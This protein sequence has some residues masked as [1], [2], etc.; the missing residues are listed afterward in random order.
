MLKKTLF[1]LSLV[2]ALVFAGAALAGKTAGTSSITGP[3]VVAASPA[4]SAAAATSTIT[5]HFGDTITFDVSSTQ[6]AAPFVNLLCYQNGQLVAEGW[7]SFFAGGL[8]DGTFRLYSG[9]WTGGAAD[10]TANLDMFVN[11]K[12]KVLASTSFQV[13]A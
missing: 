13:A 6:T 5:P 1:A 4:G 3:F 8:G 7:T 9:T 2:L 12:W 10:C 11:Y